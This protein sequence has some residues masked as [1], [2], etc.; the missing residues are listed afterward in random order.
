MGQVSPLLSIL[1]GS[2]DRPDALIRC[3]KSV[4]TQTYKNLEVLVLDDNS[5]EKLCGKLMEVVADGRVKCIRSDTTVGVAGGRNKLIRGAKGDF[6]VILDDDAAFRKNDSISRII[7][8]FALHP[9]VGLFAFKIIDIIDEKEVGVRVPFRRAVIKLNPEIINL[10]QYVSYFLGGGH[11][12][13]KDVFE[14][15]GPYQEDFFFSGEELDL[16]YKIIQNGYRLFYTPDVVVDHYIK[17][18]DPL[19]K[20][21]RRKYLYFTVRNKIWI[22]YKYLPWFA[23]VVNSI[24]W[25]GI[26]IVISFFN[27]GFIQTIRG[28]IDG[29]RSLK[30]VKRTP[31]SKEAIR[32]IRLNNGRIFY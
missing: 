1:V 24:I 26:R 9:D 4:L 12:V 22:N 15:C 19:T 17:Y 2:K 31:M 16:S 20:L 25:A 6:L 11:A 28:I 7:D 5:D 27:G 30:K 29:F 21:V 14:K 3:V 32:Y 13:R 23:F 18:S 8:L 10:H